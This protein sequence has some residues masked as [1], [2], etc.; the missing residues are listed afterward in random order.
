[1]KSARTQ[2]AMGV[3]FLPSQAFPLPLF[4]PPHLSLSFFSFSSPAVEAKRVVVKSDISQ[5]RE[6]RI[7][8]TYLFQV[9]FSFLPFFLLFSLPPPFLQGV[10]LVAQS[11]ARTRAVKKRVAAGMMIPDLGI[12]FSYSPLLF[13]PF[14]FFLLPPLPS[15]S[16]P[17]PRR[18][19]NWGR[20]F[21][22]AN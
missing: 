6:Y 20:H 17:F 8:F 16:S 13:S 7:E 19:K 2:V 12:F 9:P 3:S 5:H 22:I 4:F 1:V 10:A 15:F 11:V 18:L 14:F 21:G